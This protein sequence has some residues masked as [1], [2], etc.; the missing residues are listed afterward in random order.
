MPCTAT[1]EPEA[2]HQPPPHAR[3]RARLRSL[4]LVGVGRVRGAAYIGVEF[5]VYETLKRQWELQ[6]GASAG[7]LI[8]PGAGTNWGGVV[9]DAYVQ[10]LK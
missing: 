9:A 6:T 3:A 10:L 4:V 1:R 5:M 7:T 2:R 8:L